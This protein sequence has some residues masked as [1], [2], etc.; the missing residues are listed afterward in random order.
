MEYAQPLASQSSLNEQES[1]RAPY[2]SGRQESEVDE[3]QTYQESNYWEVEQHQS[4]ESKGKRKTQ[5]FV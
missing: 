1:R 3:S 4:R 5:P 2:F